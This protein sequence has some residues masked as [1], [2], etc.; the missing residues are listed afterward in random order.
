MAAL[1]RLS[2]ATGREAQV[3]DK[4]IAVLDDDA[5]V[6]SA[7]V[8]LLASVGF[9]CEAFET[10]EAYLQ[11]DVLNRTSCLI[12]D[13]RMPGLNGLELQRLL[14]DQHRTLPIIFITSFPDERIRQQAIEGGAICY[15]PKPYSEEEL[16]GCIRLALETPAPRRD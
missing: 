11:S 9:A 2:W 10:A 15:L 16:L 8:D 3:T 12:L 6:R 4:V 13:V 1:A 14:T 5:S 7:T